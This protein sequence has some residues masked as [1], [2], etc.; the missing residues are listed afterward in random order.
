[1]GLK[2][3]NEERLKIK[4]QI[5]KMLYRFLYEQKIDELFKVT[6]AN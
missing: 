5:L 2:D 1:M 4:N 6:D 3:K